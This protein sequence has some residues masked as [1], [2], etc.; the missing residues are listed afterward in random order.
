MKTFFPKLGL[1]CTKELNS[2]N[3][4]WTDWVTE[5]FYHKVSN[6]RMAVGAGIVRKDCWFSWC[7]RNRNRWWLAW[8]GRGWGDPRSTSHRD[9]ERRDWPRYQSRQQQAPYLKII[10]ML[11]NVSLESSDCLFNFNDHFYFSN[12]INSNE[13]LP[14]LPKSRKIFGHSWKLKKATRRNG[15]SEN[16]LLHEKRRL[17]NLK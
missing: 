11:M 9:R 5:D 2:I 8:R 17:N 6:K 16:F 14:I 15:G 3:K 4:N 12:L 7:F 10:L 1:Y 13:I